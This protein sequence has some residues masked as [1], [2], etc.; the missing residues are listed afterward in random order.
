MTTT[1]PARGSVLEPGRRLSPSPQRDRSWRLLITLLGA[2]V[3]ILLLLGLTAISVSS[4]LS[5][6]GFTDISA[7]TGLGTPSTLE[8]TNDVGDVHVLHTADVDEV[9]LAFVDDGSTA[10]PG[11]D[12]T[13]RADVARTGDTDSSRVEVS[14]PGGPAV[15]PW[16][17]DT[18]DLLLLIPEDHDLSLD[19]TSSVGD[20]DATGR[21]SSLAV[22][23]D[24]GDVRLASVSAPGGLTATSEV[25]DVEIELEG[26]TPDTVEVTTGVGDVYLLLPVDASGDVTA[27]SDL[28][29]IDLTAPGTGRWTVTASADL[30]ERIVDPSLAAGDQD[31]VGT[32]TVTSE[33]G[34]VTVSR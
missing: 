10:L 8:L 3:L 14:Q 30:G 28:G 22:T 13:V 17:H 34:D 18:H 5:S 32:L 29:T 19:L 15:V 4:W 23:S 25:G 33:V 1:L 21:Y 20:I 16:E 27:R 6:R 7:T 9:T 26:P 11:A 12:A 2:I 31:P 24:V